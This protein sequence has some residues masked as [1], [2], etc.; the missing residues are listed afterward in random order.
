MIKIKLIAIH[1][2]L[3]QST[4]TFND[5]VHLEKYITHF[6]GYISNVS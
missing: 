3:N 2:S 5:D 6:E 1:S 4:S